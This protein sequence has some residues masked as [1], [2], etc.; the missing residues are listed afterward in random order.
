M[1]NTNYFISYTLLV[2]AMKKKY[3][4]IIS[5]LTAVILVGLNFVIKDK[6]LL[7]KISLFLSGLISILISYF[8]AI[9]Y[10]KNGLIIGLIVGI[11]VSII[12]VIIH[13]FF[14]KIYFDTLYI[15]LLIFILCG[16][17]GGVLG[18]NKKTD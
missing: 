12:S 11:T 13:Y 4:I 1:C 15:R 18:V 14:S 17:S 9:N 10:K 5:I 7:N 16:A 3:L 2:M 6:E 8:I